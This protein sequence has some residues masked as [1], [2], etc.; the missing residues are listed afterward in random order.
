MSSVPVAGT[1]V[2]Q[3]ACR[4][5]YSSSSVNSCFKCAQRSPVTNWRC[6]LMVALRLTTPVTLGSNPSLCHILLFIFHKVFTPLGIR[7][8]LGLGL[9]FLVVRDSIS[10]L[11][12]RCY[13]TAGTRYLVARV[14]VTSTVD[15]TF[16]NR[17]EKCVQTRMMRMNGYSLGLLFSKAYENLNEDRPKLSAMKM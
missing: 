16:K 10:I 4:L 12:L 7:L 9:V 5:C 11:S 17:S 8:G 13:S 3:L 14:P 2:E 1:L 6:S 15:R